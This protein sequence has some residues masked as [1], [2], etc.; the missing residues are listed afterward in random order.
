MISKNRIFLLK[1]SWLIEEDGLLFDIEPITLFKE[2]DC[3]LFYPCTEKEKSQIP[4]FSRPL[5]SFRT[6]VKGFEPPQNPP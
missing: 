4:Y 3:C 1:I 5:A 2:R 6:S